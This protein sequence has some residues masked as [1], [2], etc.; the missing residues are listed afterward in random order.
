V[1]QSAWYYEPLI[2]AAVGHFVRR[3]HP[4]LGA[5]ILGA[6]GYAAAQ[7]SRVGQAVRGMVSQNFG[8][9]EA[10]AAL[11]PGYV[12]Q[13][14]GQHVAGLLAARDAQGYGAQGYGDA[15]AYVEARGYDAAGTVSPDV[16]AL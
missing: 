16:G 9:G 3:K 2:L 10:G 5:G 14:I 7:N 8:A 6:A 4:E 11:D 12:Q 15:G 1:L 13:A